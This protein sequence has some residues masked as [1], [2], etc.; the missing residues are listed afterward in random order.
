MK[1]WIK[2]SAWVVVVLGVSLLLIVGIYLSPIG[3]APPVQL[4]NQVENSP[5]T[6]VIM[7]DKGKDV[8]L[9]LL[10]DQL[11]IPIPRWFIKLFR[12]TSIT[13]TTHIDTEEEAVSVNGLY[14]TPKGSG[15]IYRFA[16]SNPVLD[17]FEGIQWDPDP[18]QQLANRHIALTGK[19]PIDELAKNDVDQLW[20][21]T[22][23]PSR[24]YMAHD[25]YVEGL[26]DNRIGEGYLAGASLLNALGIDLSEKNQNITI[27]SFQFV[28]TMRLTLDIG[29]DNALEIYIAMELE[30]NK[31][32]RIGAVNLK[33]GMS[34]AFAEWG[35]KLKQEHGVTLTGKRED[36]DHLSEFKY[37]VSDARPILSSMVEK[38][39]IP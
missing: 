3:N 10:Q 22:L 19:V 37:R 18:I 23:T 30:P 5:L 25:H 8:E 13:L 31:Q 26:V 21:N 32:N 14:A 35:K 1:R 17:Q 24:L 12:P 34:E 27:S 36:K 6:I 7:P 20:N 16:N 4:A 39:M 33:S 28:R 38:F 11:S 2:R 29:T 9:E 15:I